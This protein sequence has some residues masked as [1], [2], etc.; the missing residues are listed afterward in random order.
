MVTHC[1]NCQNELIASIDDDPNGDKNV[2]CTRC[3]AEEAHDFDVE[4]NAV[5][6]RYGNRIEDKP[7]TMRGLVIDRLHT[8]KHLGY[9]RYRGMD[10]DLMT[11]ET[12][13]A[14][15]RWSCKQR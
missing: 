6:D 14:E 15:Y 13:L 8:L 4:P 5:F 1:L 7:N 9:P 12:L 3:I 2:I 11:D 10:F